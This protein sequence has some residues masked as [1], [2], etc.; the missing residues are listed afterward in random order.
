MAAVLLVLS[1]ILG[2]TVISLAGVTT[3]EWVI[4]GLTVADDA[5]QGIKMAQELYALSQNPAFRAWVAANG[6]TAIRLR[7]GIQTFNGISN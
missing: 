7:P 4:V 5:K 6:D 2:H 3:L 1:L